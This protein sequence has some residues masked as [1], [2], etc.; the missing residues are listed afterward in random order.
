MLWLHRA[1]LVKLNRLNVSMRCKVFRLAQGLSYP[2]FVLL[3]RCLCALSAIPVGESGN[4]VEC[5]LSWACLCL[6]G[7]GLGS[8]EMRGLRRRRSMVMY[9]VAWMSSWALRASLLW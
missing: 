3:S 6:Y 1:V 9:F 2:I 8:W 5:G 7:N 4:E